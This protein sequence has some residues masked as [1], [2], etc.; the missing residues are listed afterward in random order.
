MTRGRPLYAAQRFTK[1]GYVRC[2]T[3]PA[4]DRRRRNR[5]ARALRAAGGEPDSTNVRWPSRNHRSSVPISRMSWAI[6][7]VGTTG[8]A[9]K[10]SAPAGQLDHR[11]GIS[12]APGTIHKR[13]GWRRVRVLSPDH[14]PPPRRVVRL[15]PVSLA[16][17]LN[18][19]AAIFS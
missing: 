8:A 2:P 13:R 14:V 18:G 6:A 16:A 19:A 15:P 1:A 7:S 5:P 4:L 10:A 9:S 11:A 3:I 12:A 17:A